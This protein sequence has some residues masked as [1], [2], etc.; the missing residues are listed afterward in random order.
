M[1]LQLIRIIVRAARFGPRTAAR[2]VWYA[3]NQFF[4]YHR[5]FPREKTAYC[6]TYYNEICQPQAKIV[7]EKL[8]GRLFVFDTLDA[9]GRLAGLRSAALEPLPVFIWAGFTDYVTE[10]DFQDVYNH[11]TSPARNEPL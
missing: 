3:N 2:D 11:T 10:G 1:T 8:T 4:N 9:V 7:C 6:R 5:A